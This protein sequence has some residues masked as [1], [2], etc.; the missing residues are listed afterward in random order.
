MK[1]IILTGGKSSRMG[2][3]KASLKIGGVTQLDRIL[4]IVRPLTD[5]IFLSVAH[6]HTGDAHLPTL[7]RPR[8]G[9]GTSGRASGC[10]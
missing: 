7:P 10:F 2:Q 1:A 6:D 3:D 8:A 4:S 5:E 9:S